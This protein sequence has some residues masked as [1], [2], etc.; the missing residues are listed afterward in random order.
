MNWYIWLT[1]QK[2]IFF[3]QLQSTQNFA[4]TSNHLMKCNDLDIIIKILISPKGKAP[5]PDPDSKSPKSLDFVL[6]FKL[7]P[8]KPVVV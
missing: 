7:F 1:I 5:F 3:A 6:F 8:K 2:N 4:Y